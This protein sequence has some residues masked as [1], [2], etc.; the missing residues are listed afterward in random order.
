MSLDATKDD[1]HSQT[2]T[3]VI[4]NFSEFG[5]P[6]LEILNIP[7]GNL[8][9]AMK[10]FRQNPNVDFVEP[11][12]LIQT[13]ITSDDPV[14]P[15]SAESVPNDPSYNLLWGLHNTGQSGGTVD[16]DIDAP[17]AWELSTG[18]D[19][20][21]IAVV[22]TG[23]EYT[24]PDLAANMWV[25][26]HD[27]VDGV[28]NDGNGY[29]D[30]Y[31]GW[32]FA[33][34]DN[35]PAD[36]NGH[37]THCAGT[38]AAVGNNGAGITGVNW[39]AKIMPLKFLDSSGSGYTSNA[40]SAILYANKMGAKVISNSW[41]SYGNS[42]AL[43]DAIDA[44]PAVVVCAAGN[45]GT[46]GIGDD[47]DITPHYPSSY[48]SSNI[49]S[50]ASITR[51]NARSS[52][53]NWGLTSV[54]LAAPGSQIYST[55]PSGTYRYLSGTSMATPY[56]SGVVALLMSKEPTLPNSELIRRILSSTD[57]VPDFSGKSVSGGRVNAYRALSGATPTPVVT[58]TATV[59]PTPVV[60]ATATA[61][62]TPVVTATATATPTP[63]VT[64][65]A[66]VTPT[67]VVT[68]TTTVTPTPVVTA[69]TTVTP[70]PVVTATAP[71]TP[72]PVVTATAPA[73]ATPVVTATAPATATPVVTATA[74]ATATP[75]PEFI[76]ASFSADHLSGPAPLTIHFTDTSKGKP[77]SWFWYFNDGTK[78]TGQNPIKTYRNPGN[79][80]VMLMVKKNNLADVV[81]KKDLIQ[82]TS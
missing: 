27:P 14:S 11:D 21:I 22:D 25:N 43:K 31:R 72:T 19:N 7:D 20:T 71:A 79:Y 54:D 16:V 9:G 75:V 5:L 10:I 56:V 74:P 1:L 37:G 82:V 47:N 69:T 78:S 12:Y 17:E 46:D 41:G 73:T 63:V 45:G 13:N 33:N 50:V 61:T 59:T 65:T 55:Y 32:D 77:T 28:D 66:T 53:S 51:N 38:M 81:M 64:A 18:S 70:T 40:I 36:D 35:D 6:G 80:S 15:A 23:V 34:S 4:T 60:T 68:A 58:A 67:P 52:F 24:H 76:N 48:V 62:P 26:S 8:S 39:K 42:Q 57:A 29:I 44:S 3:K 49:I 30:D 2:R